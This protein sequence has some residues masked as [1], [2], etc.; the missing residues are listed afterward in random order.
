MLIHTSP[1]LCLMVKSLTFWAFLFLEL[2]WLSTGQEDEWVP[3]A[4]WGVFPPLLLP[5][6]QKL[7]SWG[8]I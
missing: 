4:V 1:A 7:G 6:G 5:L 2:T 8:D 3:W